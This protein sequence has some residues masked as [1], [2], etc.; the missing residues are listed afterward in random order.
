MIRKERGSERECMREG[1]RRRESERRERRSN[2]G[3]ERESVEEMGEGRGG[4]IKE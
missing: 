2:G 4:G 1:E 3:I